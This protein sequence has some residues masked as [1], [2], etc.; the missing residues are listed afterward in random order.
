MTSA[1]RLSDAVKHLMSVE[2]N[3]H[4]YDG[5]S[6]IDAIGWMR[7]ESALGSR[8]VVLL[9]APPADEQTMDHVARR[10]LIAV[11]RQSQQNTTDT[12]AA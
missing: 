5:T 9:T 1:F 12:K 11:V 7:V 3:G 2:W 10:L 4:S 6:T 8:I